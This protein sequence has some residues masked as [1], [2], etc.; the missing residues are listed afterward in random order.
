MRT[1]DNDR[2]LGTYLTTVDTKGNAFRVQDSS[3]AMEPCVWI[4]TD[5]IT[6]NHMGHDMH[7]ALHINVEKA[8]A[9]RDAL[10][11]F[12]RLAESQ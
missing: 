5:Q 10:D 2:G 11:E 4:F 3:S 1:V 7:A 12:I 6:G 9:L 8:K